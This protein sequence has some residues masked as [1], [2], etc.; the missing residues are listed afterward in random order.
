MWTGEISKFKQ[1]T[2]SG[3]GHALMPVLH[4]QMD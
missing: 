2:K 1:K 4:L 3:F